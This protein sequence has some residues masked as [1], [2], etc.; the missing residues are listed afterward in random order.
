MFPPQPTPPQ[1][2]SLLSSLLQFSLNFTFVLS[3]HNVE[4]YILGGVCVC[5]CVC[6]RERELCNQMSCVHTQTNTTNGIT[7]EKRDLSVIEGEEFHGNLIYH[8]NLLTN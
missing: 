2:K 3:T 7:Y 6:M 1:E 4:W 8:N 5:V